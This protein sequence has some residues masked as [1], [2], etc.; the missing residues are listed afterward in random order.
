MSAEPW[1]AGP[2]PNFRMEATEFDGNL[3]SCFLES[4]VR[5]VG[6]A[7]IDDAA[8]PPPLPSVPW[9]GAQYWLYMS[10]PDAA[11]VCLIGVFL[12][13]GCWSVFS[14]A[15][16]RLVATSKLPSRIMLFFNMRS[17][18][19]LWIDRRRE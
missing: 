18:F 8:G 16:Q 4:W 17:S 3:P 1:E 9:H 10:F 7:F 13:T 5:S 12:T 11:F 6:V 15:K 14:C 19:R 2:S